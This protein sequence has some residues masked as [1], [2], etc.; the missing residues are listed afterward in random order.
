MSLRKM[1]DP[2]A[3]DPNR[4]RDAIIRKR[5]LNNDAAPSRVLAV[6]PPVIGKIRD[7]TLPVGA[8]GCCA[9]MPGSNASI[10]ELRALMV[11]ADAYP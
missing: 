2:C 3:D 7:D 11:G 6:A 4:V 5:R 10:R 8:T 1:P 9:C